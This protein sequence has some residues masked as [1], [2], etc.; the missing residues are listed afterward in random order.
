VI[1]DGSPE[2]RSVDER[3]TVPS[4][5]TPVGLETRQ[6][7]AAL[8]QRLFG[9]SKAPAH[10]GRFVVLERLGEGGM[11]TVWAAWDPELDRR[12]AIKVT[13]RRVDRARS[14]ARMRRE[15]RALARLDHPNVVTVHEVDVIDDHLYIAMELVRGGTLGTWCEEHPQGADGRFAALLDLAI[16]AARGLAA[17]HGAGMVHRDLKPS[18][19]LV[20]E[21]GRL[22]L[23]DFGLARLEVEGSPSDVESGG[24]RTVEAATG[25]GRLGDSGADAVTQMLSPEDGLAEANAGQSVTQALGPADGIAERRASPSAN[26]ALVHDDRRARAVRVVGP[27]AAPGFDKPHASEDG[28]RSDQPAT[29]G[30]TR[31][32]EILG[33]PAYMAPEQLEGRADALA[34]QFSLCTTLWEAAYGVRP[35]AGLTALARLDAIADGRP[36]LPTTP[37]DVPAWFRTVLRRG[38]A[39]DPAQRWP[40]VPTLLRALERGRG[41]RRERWLLLSGA[42]VLAGVVGLVAWVRLEPALW[43]GS[44]EEAL[45]TAWGSERRAAIAAHHD[46]ALSNELQAHAEA[47]SAAYDRACHAYAEAAPAARDDSPLHAASERL[48]CLADAREQLATVADELATMRAEDHP[49]LV[50]AL[51]TPADC[52]ERNVVPPHPLDP[53]RL[54][55]APVLGRARVLLLAGRLDAAARLLDEA[56]G[57]GLDPASPAVAGPLE[58]L[59]AGLEAARGNHAQAEHRAARALGLAE[60]VGDRETALRAWL[61]LHAAAVALGKPERARLRAERAASLA[62]RGTPTS[63]RD[64]AE[65]AAVATPSEP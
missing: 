50:H 33:T 53:A 25:G 49:A 11:G 45:A 9:A 1:R 18:N 63:L 58:E 61:R 17:V 40:D 14:V 55:A 46:V 39:H 38:L 6:L 56:S 16:Q 36:T 27:G 43:C 21:H 3:T 10:I 48:A 20:D 5:A 41:R 28:L 2:G 37:H 30:L 19:M 32:G 23:T 4:V 52:E 8:E 44:G 24:Q 59:R 57:H 35:F 65:Q 47:W 34:D 15:A 51:P 54:A 42:L 22:C 64:A 7:R 26:Q 62:R 60:R 13:R 31:A 29:G 12:V